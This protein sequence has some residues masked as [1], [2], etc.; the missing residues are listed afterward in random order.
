[1]T[2]NSRPEALLLELKVDDRW[3]EVG[4]LHKLYNKLTSRST[5]EILQNGPSYVRQQVRQ[6]ARDV[7]YRRK[8]HGNPAR[9]AQR[10]RA[11]LDRITP[12][13]TVLFLCHGNICRSPFAER[14]M[15][16]QLKARGI[17][18]ITVTSAGLLEQ[19]DR[20]SPP[21]AR[22]AANGHGIALETNAATRAD[23]ELLEQ[24]DLIL[25][26]DYRNYHDFTTRASAAADKMFLLGLFDA[27]ESI[28]IDDPHHDTLAGF[29]RSFE[30]IVDSVDGLL[31]AI[32]SRSNNGPRTS[33][34]D[35]E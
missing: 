8:L 2:G 1:M 7:Y 34:K 5:S 28:P 3:T 6:R 27:H 15:R 21:N 35:W 20:R 16:Q 11:A 30:R 24:A 25:L 10:R 9:I 23:A 18:G 17:D 33:G 26:M 31:E 12:E 29:E 13:S 22:T 19:P 4:S 32:E 14:Y